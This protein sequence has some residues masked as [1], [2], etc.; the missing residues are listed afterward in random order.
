VATASVTNTF[1]TAT[2]ITAAA[3]NTNFS[4][5]VTF[6]NSNVVHVDGSKANDCH[7]ESSQLRV[8]KCG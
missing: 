1:V 6:L 7:I 4:D 3:H 8:Q 5:L 2:T